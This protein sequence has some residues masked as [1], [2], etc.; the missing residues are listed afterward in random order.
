MDYK[1]AKKVDSTVPRD[2]WIASLSN[3]ETIYENEIEGEERP[4]VRLARYVKD[5]DLSITNLRLQVGSR[6]VK[7]PAGQE[8]YIQKSIAWG[9]SNQFSGVS[10]CIGYVQGKVCLIHEVDEMKGSRTVRGDP[11]PGSPWTIYRA[12]IRSAK[13]ERE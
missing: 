2:R 7:L 5:N 8:G 9:F 4:W 10:K 1:L 11:D 13:N 6:T 3:G 12:D